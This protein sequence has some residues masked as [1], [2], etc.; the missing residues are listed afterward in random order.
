[1]GLLFVPFHLLYLTV[2]FRNRQ[3]Q[4]LVVTRG[5]QDSACFLQLRELFGEAVEVAGNRIIEPRREF[6]GISYWI[7]ASYPESHP[8]GQISYRAQP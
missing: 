6:I 1:M 3:L 7:N 5:L 4:P 2:M 8:G